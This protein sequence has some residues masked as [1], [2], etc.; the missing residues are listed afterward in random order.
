MRLSIMA[1]LLLSMHKYQ[2]CLFEKQFERLLKRTLPL[3]EKLEQK[4]KNAHTIM[5]LVFVDWPNWGEN[6]L[7]YLIF[8]W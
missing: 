1:Q 5:A 3:Q 8:P 2:A 7:G 6:E 4:P